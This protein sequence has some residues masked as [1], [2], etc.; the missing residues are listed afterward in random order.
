M[1]ALRQQISV[2]S[3][4]MNQLKAEIIQVKSSHATLHQS[5]V[6]SNGQSARSFADV[7]SRFA[8]LEMKIDAIQTETVDSIN[9]HF[10]GSED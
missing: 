6:D 9:L 7:K 5:S 8:S 2:I 10:Q 4:E 1:D 3:D